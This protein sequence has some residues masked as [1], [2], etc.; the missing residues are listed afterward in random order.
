MIT[1]IVL[2]VQKIGFQT[3]GFAARIIWMSSRMFRPR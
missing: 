3:H 2:I 1:G